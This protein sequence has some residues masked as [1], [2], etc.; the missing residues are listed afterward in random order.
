MHIYRYNTPTKQAKRVPNVWGKVMFI[1]SMCGDTGLV[2][3]S[4][5][6]EQI[7]V[8]VTVSIQSWCAAHNGNAVRCVHTGM[9]VHGCSY[10][11]RIF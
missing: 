5:V 6:Y 11:I 7:H 1:R 8:M 2:E 3:Y 4:L 9:Y 10:G